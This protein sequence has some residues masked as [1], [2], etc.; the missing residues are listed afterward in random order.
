MYFQ[1]PNNNQPN[2]K[3]FSA[4]LFL[5]AAFN[6]KQN[7]LKRQL[8]LP[9]ANINVAD[10][11]GETALHSVLDTGH[12]DIELVRFLLDHGAD[13]HAVNSDGDTPLHIAVSFDHKDEVSLLLNKGADINFRNFDGRT[14]LHMIGQFNSPTT[15][16]LLLQKGVNIDAVDNEGNT[17]LHLAVVEAELIMFDGLEGFDTAART[18]HLLLEQ[19][20]D[21]TVVNHE[22]KTA[23]DLA[24]T[25]E[26]KELLELRL[27]E[28][29]FDKVKMI[30]GSDLS[31]S[32]LK[33]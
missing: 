16:A 22:G 19:G 10:S 24:K 4:E 29:G 15:G 2:Q 13:I 1:A 30:D 12:T 9:N 6:C 3:E 8:D 26:L 25:D 27:M 11:R 28:Q 5:H 33:P 20:A 21:T 23:F 7:K 18:A 31:S 17:V 14:P 32:R